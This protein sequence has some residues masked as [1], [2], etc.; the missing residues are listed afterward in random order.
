M[1]NFAQQIRSRLEGSVGLRVA[2][3]AGALIVFALFLVPHQIRSAIALKATYYF[4]A[5]AGIALIAGAVFGWMT[6]SRRV[7]FW[8]V[9]I[10]FIPL[11]VLML[12]NAQK[13][14]I[15][16]ELANRADDL[17]PDAA[18][19]ILDYENPPPRTVA[20]SAGSARNALTPTGEKAGRATPETSDAAA[21]TQAW[22]YVDRAAEYS[23]KGDYDRAIAELAEAIRIDPRYVRAYISRGIAWRKKGDLERALVDF[24]EAIR[25]DPKL[26]RAYVSRG[27]AWTKSG[28]L[29][30]AIA[31]Y[32]D[33]I[34]LEP[35]LALAYTERG[36]A[37]QTKGDLDRAM[38]DYNDAIRL[39]P[40]I[41][42]AYHNRGVAWHNKSDL[43]RALADYN[44]AIRLS[45]KFALVYANRGW[46]FCSKGLPDKALTDFRQAM[47]LE[48][49]NERAIKGL[50][51]VEQAVARSR[52]KPTSSTR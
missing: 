28:D 15:P 52:A 42:R 46:I 29:D 23:S 36:F 9:G 32:N 6:Y 22:P 34:R 18:R 49:G 51:C 8:T 48:P 20:E 24:N 44:D 12:A 26:A 13:G 37:W 16:L 45:P 47:T 35:K 27:I 30:R 50:N 17:A 7:F 43:D 19:A 38:A 3:L 10:V 41:A 31:D 14:L 2:A 5:P 39:D 21:P 4:A 1:T 25:L 40:R 11:S 33:A